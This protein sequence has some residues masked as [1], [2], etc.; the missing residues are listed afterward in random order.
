MGYEGIRSGHARHRLRRGSGGALPAGARGPGW[1]AGSGGDP[2]ESIQI[3][4]RATAPGL[5][6]TPE[7]LVTNGLGGFAAGTTA[8]PAARRYHGWLIAALAPPV[9]RRLLW[10]ATEEWLHTPAGPFPLST[11]DY[12]D[13]WHPDG[14]R[15]LVSFRLYP[16][17]T[18]LW[19]VD[20]ILIERTVFMVRGQNTTVARW[21]LISGPPVELELRPLA[22][23]RDY[24]HTTRAS[25]WDFRQD[26]AGHGV[27][28][29]AYPGAPPLCF[30]G[31]PEARYEPRGEWYY[32]FHYP[33]EAERGLEH[34]EDHFCPGHF[35]LRL[36]GPGDAAVLVGHC[37]VPAAGDAPGDPVPAPPWRA[38]PAA[39][40]HWAEDAYR[41][42]VDRRRRLLAAFPRGDVDFQRL[43]LAAD[44]FV[45]WRRTTRAATVIAG[46]PWFTDWGRDAM[47]SLPGLLLAT[48]RHGLAREVLLTFAAYRREGLVPNRFV[49]DG[50]GADYNAADAPLWFVYAVWKYAMATGDDDTVGRELLPAAE[51]VCRH[52]LRGTR[53]GIGCRPDGLVDVTG[54][55]VPLTWMDA[56]VDGWVVTPRR[57]APVEINALW[58]NALR[59]V[60]SLARKLKAP[61]ASEWRR[62]ALA[63]QR[64]F[65]ERFPLPQGWLRD[66]VPPAGAPA[67]ATGA[68]EE[69]RPNQLLAVALPF[70]VLGRAAGGRIV[71]ETAR[72]LLTPVGLRTLAPEEPGYR[73]VYAGDQWRRDAAYHQGTVWP[74][75]L[76]PFASALLRCRGRGGAA[77]EEVR[78]LLDPLRRHL[79]AEG[80]LGH[81]SEIFDGD[82]PYRARGCFAQ[83][84]SGAEMLRVLW[85]ELGDG[86]AGRGDHVRGGAGRGA[87]D[88][89]G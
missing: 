16:F 19:A 15:R 66:F 69:L 84:W 18:W 25:G 68:G 14:W 33:I 55:G 49:D 20:G 27:V 82:P 78:R 39:L 76:G 72:R 2:W 48:G 53:Y 64:S 61:G 86:H 21:R 29:T 58:Y 28:L 23:C 3:V 62:L 24:H 51:D 41:R 65:T 40:F 31:G 89:L 1:A 79:V 6:E 47:I 43:A 71:A 75:L 11:H 54:E 35:R 46:Y 26:V 9:E 70:P 37:P 85:E 83:A 80:A 52:Y 45:A 7:W 87:G 13:T 12:G 50:Q 32:G 57:G 63:V 4:W 10:A 30:A 8:G 36:A 22:N 34:V 81:V 17:P 42:A 73:G 74:W 88:V 38:G 44:D 56:Q 59:S 77:R 60:E 67:M 5:G